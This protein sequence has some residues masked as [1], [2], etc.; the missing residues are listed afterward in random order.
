MYN[1]DSTSDSETATMRS[2]TRQK[3]DVVEAPAVAAARSAPR[4]RLDAVSLAKPATARPAARP[5]R[6]VFH[7]TVQVTRV[8]EWFVEAETADEARA[9][10]ESGNGQRS[11]IGECTHFEISHLID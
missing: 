11:Q 5:K 1:A 10:L 8:E 3:L 7:A 2:A 9:L 4:P 6:R